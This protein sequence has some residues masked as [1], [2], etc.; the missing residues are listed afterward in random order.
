MAEPTCQPTCIYGALPNQLS[1]LQTIRKYLKTCSLNTFSSFSV[2]H[3]CFPTLRTLFLKLVP[4]A[5]NCVRAST[6]P[7][8]YLDTAQACIGYTFGITDVNLSIFTTTNREMYSTSLNSKPA[9]HPTQGMEVE[10]EHKFQQLSLGSKEEI[11]ERNLTHVDKVTCNFKISN[12]PDPCRPCPLVLV[13]HD[14]VSDCFQEASRTAI[15]YARRHFNRLRLRHCQP[16]H[17]RQY[18]FHSH[19]FAPINSLDL[20]GS[21]NHLCFSSR[22]LFLFHV[23]SICLPSLIPFAFLVL[24]LVK[25]RGISS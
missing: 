13:S 3:A 9:I 10:Q 7:P 24:F 6:A 1:I 12:R 17:H 18:C 19:S 15:S 20:D 25:V 8:F 21:L 5:S 4:G 23:S 2:T 14:A 16:H 22:L 11:E